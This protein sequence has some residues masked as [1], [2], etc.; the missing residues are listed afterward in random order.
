M[1]L[2]ALDE[3]IEALHGRADPKTL[4]RARSVRARAGERVLLSGAHT[5]VALAGST[6]SGKSSLFNALSGADLSPAGVRRPTTAKAHACVWGVEGAAPL[7]QWLGVP[8]RQTAWQHGAVVEDQPELDGLVLLD[9]P[10][11]DSNVLDHR[12]EVD[13]LIE[14]VDLLVWVVDP[15]KY[16]DE[17]L[18]DRYLRR[19]AGHAAVTVV[20]LNQ[21]DTLNPFAAAECAAD[22]ARLVE[23]D[24]LRRA[25]VR[26]CSART[27][28][29]LDD[30]RAVFAAAVTR[31][32]AGN[33]RLVADVESVVY[34]LAPA[35]SLDAQPE[36][37]PG[38]AELVEALASS[39]GVPVIGEA[40]EQ[41]WQRRAAGTLGWPPIR[42][43]RLLRPDPLRRLKLHGRE[44]R[45]LRAMV[46]SS[47]PEP[48]PAQQAQVERAVR[49]VCDGASRDLPPRW[50]KSVRGAAGASGGDV[51]DALDEAVVGTDLEVDRTPVWWRVGS[52][53]QW[54]VTLAAVAGAAWLLVLAFGSHLGLPDASSPSW[55]GVSLPSVLLVGGLVVG[56]AIAVL[57]RSVGRTEAMLR[58]ERAESRLRAAVESVA[59]RLVIGPVEAELQRHQQARD[60]LSRASGE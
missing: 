55:L 38:R 21:I 46:H 40:V 39:A 45:D 52:F 37:S 43:L 31:R 57:G 48:T 35:V 29:G 42:W 23:L 6:G 17:A 3:A 18:H 14:L 26:T 33:D 7:V 60:A 49:R 11:H 15:Q 59:D 24:G 25:H 13:R 50:Q 2:T 27:G 16:A 53:V 36:V 34:A 20:L 30:V 4:A 47:V 44:R 51:R 10:D 9:L 41:S 22:L 19:L 1:M 12:L 32:Q 54:L 58:R 28:A 56:G 8:R 5:V